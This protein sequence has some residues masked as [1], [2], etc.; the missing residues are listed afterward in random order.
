LEGLSFFFSAGTADLS[1]EEFARDGGSG[2][3]GLCP[4]TGSLLG[5]AVP[6]FGMASLMPS[7]VE[8]IRVNRFVIDGFSTL[9]FVAEA[10]ASLEGVLVPLGRTFGLDS[11]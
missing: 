6:L 2:L 7:R 5:V 11:K 8:N 10:I 3:A 9:G 1:V 4:L